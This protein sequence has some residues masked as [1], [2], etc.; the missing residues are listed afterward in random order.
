MLQMNLAFKELINFLNSTTIKNTYFAN[1]LL[2]NQVDSRCRSL[3]PERYNP[4]YKHI[5]GE[6]I[7]SEDYHGVGNDPTFISSSIQMSD[8]SVWYNKHV[9]TQFDEVM[10]ITSLDTG[11][12]IAF[13]K[14]NLHGSGN[15]KK[16]LAAYR[17]PSRY[18]ELLCERYPL[19]VDLI[20]AIVYPVPSTEIQIEELLEAPNYTLLQ[21]DES[22]L[23]ANERTSLIA[24][25]QTAL[26]VIKVR[27][28][29]PEYAFEDGYPI[30]YWGV[31]WNALLLQLLAQRQQ[32]IRTPKA[33]PVH[34]WEYLQSNGLEGYRGV[35]SSTQEMWLYRNLRYL[36]KNRGKHHVLI[37]LIENI[38]NESGI[39]ATTKTAVLNTEDI[40]DHGY[41]ATPE[42]LTEPLDSDQIISLPATQESL[43]TVISKEHKEGLEPVFN[44][45]V[46]EEQ[47]DILTHMGSTYLPTKLIEL[48]RI[49]FN[50]RYYD[51]F[52][53][54]ATDTILAMVSRLQQNNVI[55]RFMVNTDGTE[56]VLDM[57]EMVALLYY[58]TLCEIGDPRAIADDGSLITDVTIPSKSY[59]DIVFN[60]HK[61]EIPKTLTWHPWHRGQRA[62][63][64]D[65]VYTY[66]LDRFIDVDDMLQ[67]Y[68]NLDRVDLPSEVGS[69][70]QTMFL[71]MKRH[72]TYACG[73]GDYHTNKAVDVVYQAVLQPGWVEFE[74]VPDEK[75]YTDWFG[76]NKELGNY[77][78]TL[79]MQED[80]KSAISS[81]GTMLIDQLLQGCDL[82]YVRGNIDD[83]KYLKLK[84]LVIKLCSYNIAFMDTQ[85]QTN[86]SRTSVPIV[87]GTHSR[88]TE[89]TRYFFM[90]RPNQRTVRKDTE[91][92]RK[93][94]MSLVVNRVVEETN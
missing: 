57:G 21:Y 55:Y 65:I 84:Q 87:M 62:E 56:L 46:V 63:D 66:P 33:H 42:I 53:L 78:R 92:T 70:I 59:L 58:T 18:Y 17:L 28:D 81:L 43:E 16:T 52:C 73:V 82:A 20:K 11:E 24:R 14:E 29:V 88:E 1:Y 2:A 36:K 35:L 7:L 72:Q 61:P 30:A 40:L 79:K 32:N 80:F 22:L 77:I 86:T 44:E 34:I 26:E 69:Y 23:N 19:Q 37:K 91:V 6:Y 25:L 68:I 3:L 4:Y 60:F 47:R 67:D 8:G 50:T 45:D 83:T 74:L 54:L 94:T 9:Y 41:K 10:I 85:S 27:W 31:I 76:V 13:T 15:H 39:T 75:T 48:S 49:L 71:M 64:K 38:L 12:E 89:V 90:N 51:L 93:Q 5:L